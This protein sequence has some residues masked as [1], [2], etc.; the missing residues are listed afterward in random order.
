MSLPPNEECRG[1]NRGTLEENDTPTTANCTSV[2]DPRAR[3][4]H[5]I[6]AVTRQAVTR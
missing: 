1:I 4:G 5:L 2:T 3:G 6:G